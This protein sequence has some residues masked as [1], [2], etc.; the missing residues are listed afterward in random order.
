MHS[1]RSDYTSI[2]VSLEK[3]PSNNSNRS[4]PKPI[5]FFGFAVDSSCWLRLFLSANSTSNMC[6]WSVMILQPLYNFLLV[7]FIQFTYFTCRIRRR[8]NPLSRDFGWSKTY[9]QW[10][11]SESTFIT[12]DSI[13][14]TPVQCLL[15]L[16]SKQQLSYLTNHRE[17]ILFR[18]SA[19]N[20][21]C[22]I[23]DSLELLQIFLD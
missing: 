3:F 10:Q 14:Q 22:F 7:Y 6:A 9:I 1:L 19:R 8:R 2:N 12:S 21:K 18:D 13:E 23:S 20:R 5:H 16:N 11:L 17:N 15:I 4:K